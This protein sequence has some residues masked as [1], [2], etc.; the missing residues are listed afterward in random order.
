MSRGRVSV[1]AR[2]GDGTRYAVHHGCCGV[3]H[4]ESRGEWEQHDGWGRRC[5]RR[6]MASGQRRRRPQ[7]RVRGD[8]DYDGVLLRQ[9]EDF[10]VSG[11]SRAGSPGRA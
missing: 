8:V 3:H 5:A 9:K 2:G 4:F 10:L 11:P 6:G 7:S 1:S